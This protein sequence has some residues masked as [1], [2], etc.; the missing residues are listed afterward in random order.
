LSSSEK[1]LGGV[2]F[3]GEFIDRELQRGILTRLADTYPKMADVG[4]VFGSVSKPIMVNLSY[5]EEHGLLTTSW[6][7]RRDD[8]PTGARISAR[9]LDFLAD[10]G[11]LTAMLGILTVRSDERQLKQIL[12]DRVNSSNEPKDIKTR[13]IETIRGL[14]ADLTKE[15]MVEAAK[16]GLEQIPNIAQWIMS[17]TK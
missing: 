3:V 10:D 7:N 13:L 14:P 11:G 12:I 5:L 4:S 15:A 9:G 8:F 6:I 1:K 16:S 2:A 17:L